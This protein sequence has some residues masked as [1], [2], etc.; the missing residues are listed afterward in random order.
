VRDRSDAGRGP[1]PRS[2]RI[3]AADVV[4]RGARDAVILKPAGLSSEA[5]GTGASAPETLLT[6]ARALLGWPDA[7]L[8]HRIDRPTRGFVVVARDRD[9]V[10]AHNESI[11]AGTWTKHYLAL[12]AP[13]ERGADAGALVGQHR[14][15]LRRDGQVSRVVR[16]GGDPSSLTVVAAAPAPGR[17]GEWHALIKLETGRFHQI[18]AMLSNLGFPLVGDRDYGG[19]PGAMYLDHASLWFPS[20][21]GGRM[22]RAWLA[23]DRGREALDPAISVA[24]R[25]C[26]A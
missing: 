8:P 18:R 2:P 3:G 9:A 15:Y 23:E 5:P 20:I 4:L 1:S 7:Q 24:L 19:A 16:S 14:A 21:D 26:V 17:P 25:D 22:Q 10:A 11:R 12:I 13:T 6:Q